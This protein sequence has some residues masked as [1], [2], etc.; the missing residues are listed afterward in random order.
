MVGIAQPVDDTIKLFATWPGTEHNL[1]TLERAGYNR[2]QRLEKVVDDLEGGRAFV[3]DRDHPLFLPS[4]CIHAVVTLRGGFMYT[5]NGI[6]VSN[7]G[8][9]L[10]GLRKTP[11]GISHREESEISG[12]VENIIGQFDVTLDSTDPEHLM[13][14]LREALSCRDILDSL[15]LKRRKTTLWKQDMAPRLIKFFRSERF[16]LLCQTTVDP[17]AAREL[18]QRLSN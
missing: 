17:E 9:F 1:E 13:D 11:I 12:L 16:K 6:V 4:S 10:R 18:Q 8:L 15:P 7:G 14:F 3:V 2:P 5:V